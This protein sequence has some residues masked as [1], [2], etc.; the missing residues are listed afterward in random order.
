MPKCGYTCR[1]G[2]DECPVCNSSLAGVEPPAKTSS[3][4]PEKKGAE[5][6]QS[7]KPNEDKKEDQKEQESSE[8][9]SK[10]NS[11]QENKQENN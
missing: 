10:E 2:W 3:P 11:E 4:Q 6:A 9:G 5:T 7:P 8:E 1:K